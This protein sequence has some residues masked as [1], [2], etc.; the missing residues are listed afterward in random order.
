LGD[1]TVVVT[2]YFGGTLLGT[3]GLVR[4][5]GDAVRAVLEALP[6]TER[7]ERRSLLVSIPYSLYEQAKR[8]VEA[9]NGQIDEEDFATDVTLNII[10]AI[11]DL[12]PFREALVELSA[13]QAVIVEG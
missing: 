8:L 7:V 13:G 5:Y 12:P 2:R 3:G 10:F 6:R 4:A 9:H 1:I 11:D